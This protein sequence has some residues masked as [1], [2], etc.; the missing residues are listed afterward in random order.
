MAHT[1]ADDGADHHI[2]RELV[3][4]FYGKTFF[5]EYFQ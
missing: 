4:Q 3:Q 5:F 2:D 1:G